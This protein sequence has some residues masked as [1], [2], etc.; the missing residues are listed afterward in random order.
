MRRRT[1]L[2]IAVVAVVA[3]G[4]AA[5]AAV[6]NGDSSDEDVRTV[7]V[8]HGAILDKALAVGRIEPEVEISVKSK[9]SGVVS[10]EF[11]DVGDFVRAGDPLLEIKP[12]PTPLELVESRRQLELRQLELDNLGKELNRKRSLLEQGLISQNEYDLAERAYGEAELNL[13]LAQER[14]ALLEEGK[15][16]ISDQS[17]D[18]IVKSPI[19]GFILEKNVEIGDPVVPLNPYQEGT[20]IMSMAEMNALIFRGTV[21][22][23]DVGRLREGMPVEIKIGALPGSKVTGRLSKISLKARTDDNSTVFPIEIEL[24][25]SNDVVLRAGY[26]AN[27]DIIID[28]REDVL[29]IPERLI[30]TSGDTA[31]VTVLL[32]SGEREER[33]ITTGLSDAI[34]IEIIDGLEEGEKVVE[35]PPREIE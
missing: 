13:K 30:D 35:P 9:I 6:R 21:D 33:T 19:N 16:T 1:K 27:A 29:M 32:P 14:L 10:R 15:V 23:I 12:T 20:V 11:A 28:R 31:R 24:D 8:E 34:N 2:T 7:E 17:V 25:R 26:S 18:A 22:E 4:S 3:V 5:A